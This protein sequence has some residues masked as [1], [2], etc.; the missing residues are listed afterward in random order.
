M[1]DEK[2]PKKVEPRRVFSV[3]QGDSLGLK[4]K[5]MDAH[6]AGNIM[7]AI[8]SATVLVPLADLER[9]LAGGGTFKYYEPDEHGSEV[10]VAGPRRFRDE[11]PSQGEQQSA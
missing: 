6:D 1:A 10:E 9:A 4:A 5:V 8:G 7:L 11:R 3:Q 2:V